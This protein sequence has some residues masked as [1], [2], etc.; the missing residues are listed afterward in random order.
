MVRDDN[1]YQ[2]VH[3]KESIEKTYPKIPWKR[4]TCS[5]TNHYVKWLWI[6]DTY[7]S[8]KRATDQP[9]KWKSC[10]LDPQ[11]HK[12]SRVWGNFRLTQIDQM[13]S[14]D[15]FVFF[16]FWERNSVVVMV[17][18]SIMDGR[19]RMPRTALFILLT[20][21]ELLSN[22]QVMISLIVVY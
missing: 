3:S 14:G 19:K 8:R 15:F 10:L 22:E 18:W 11:F 1:Y 17:D 7:L 12:H 16:G 21:V 5:T 2:I 9:L 20:N 4:Y 6:L 13:I